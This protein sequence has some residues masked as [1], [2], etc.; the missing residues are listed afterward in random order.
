M[1]R[2]S[3]KICRRGIV[4]VMNTSGA[5]LLP[6]L[7]RSADIQQTVGRERYHKRGPWA[8]TDAHDTSRAEGSSTAFKLAFI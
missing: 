5:V 8:R 2:S 7:R 6:G 1:L 4:V 3:E